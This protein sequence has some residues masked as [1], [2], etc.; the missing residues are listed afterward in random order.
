[1]I[2]A[3]FGPTS[4]GET[5]YAADLVRSLRPGMIVLADRKLR[6]PAAGHRDRRD[7]LVRVRNGRVIRCE[8]TI[9]TSAGRRSGT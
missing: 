6:L 9:S 4:A 7:R 2:D 1:V 3:V 8:I 5:T